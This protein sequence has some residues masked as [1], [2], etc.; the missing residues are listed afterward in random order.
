MNEQ[1]T[2]TPQII[3]PFPKLYKN[4]NKNSIS[5]WEISIHPVLP[6]GYVL[7]WYYGVLNG[8]LVE[9]KK[10]VEKG[11]A[12]RSVLQQAILEATSKW[13]EKKNKELYTETIPTTNTISL[14]VG[15]QPTGGTIRPMLACSYVPDA[16]GGGGGGGGSGS[17]AYRMPF[18]C[19]VQRKYDGIRAISYLSSNSGEATIE[20]RKGI[21]FGGFSVI[22]QQLMEIYKLFPTIY[23]DGELF[24]DELPFEV[25]SGLVRLHKSNIT[26]ETAS[27]IDKIQ[28]HIYDIYDPS[29]VGLSFQ[30]RN[31]VIR[32][33]Y[34]TI[35]GSADL[36]RIRWVETEMTSSH[37]DVK[38][39]HDVFVEEGFEGI[40]LRDPR[41]VYEPNKRSKYLQKYKEFMEEEFPITGFHEGVGQETGLCIWECVTPE[42]KPFCVKPKGTQE[43]RR[44]L[45]NRGQEHIGKMLTVCFQEYSEGLIPRFP[46]GKSIRD[47]Y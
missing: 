31:A 1:I 16:V 23:L 47:I 39:M 30:E 18:P 27:Q 17:K 21:S 10:A 8:K 41:G 42:N 29:R 24:T 20:S 12:G 43:F 13:N 5:T 3:H 37:E 14:S 26:E 4:N 15:N 11:K 38:R 9:N 46:V 33:I 44:E 25:I 35:G 28:Y 2:P 34:N 22:Q 19:Y 7:V 40:M 36:S 6:D 45:Y 32:S